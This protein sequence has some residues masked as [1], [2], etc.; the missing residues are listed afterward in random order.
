MMHPLGGNF[1]AKDDHI[2]MLRPAFFSCGCGSI[3]ARLGSVLQF[4]KIHSN[5][6]DQ[7]RPAALKIAK[8]WLAQEGMYEKCPLLKQHVYGVFISPKGEWVDINQGTS[9]SVAERFQKLYD[10]YRNN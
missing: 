6:L 5:Q 4:T 10:E 8:D 9:Q 3:T 7:V 2:E 1:V